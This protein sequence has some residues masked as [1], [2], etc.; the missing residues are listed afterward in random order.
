MTGPAKAIS[1]D[2]VNALFEKVKNWG[3]WGADDERGA[4]NLI[5]E[6]KR[7]QAAELVIVGT[8]VSCALPLNTTGS[9]EN[10]RPVVHLMVGAG[11]IERAGSSSDYFAI[12]SHG[13]AHTHLDALCH[14][15]YRGQMYNGRPQS[16]VTSTGALANSIEAGKDGVVS[17]GVLLDIPRAQGR[18]WL[19]AGEAIYVEDL[20][21]AEKAM[22]VQVEEG[23]ILLIRTGRQPRRETEGP[24]Q[25]L[26]GLH[27]TALPWLHARGVAVLGCDGVSDVTPS[28]MEGGGLPVHTIAIPSM[29]LHL[30]DNMGLEELGDT[31]DRLDRYEFM[32][33]LAPLKLLRGTASPVN[34]IAM[35]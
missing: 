34:P 3:R 25:G 13:M 28:G 6:R 24:A 14:I 4:L 32:L 26:A 31:C 33:T 5:T 1:R 17:R 27:A 35:F 18:E 29:G 23:D 11:D 8:T 9:G 16:M 10:P 7:L 22:H 12:A 20:E 15:F 2:E 19:D 21:A 30:I